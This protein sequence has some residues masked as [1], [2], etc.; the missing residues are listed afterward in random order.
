MVATY[1]FSLLT[2]TKEILAGQFEQRNLY[3]CRFCFRRETPH[4]DDPFVQGVHDPLDK[5]VP[6]VFSR[7]FRYPGSR[8]V[9]RVNRDVGKLDVSDDVQFHIKL[10]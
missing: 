1:I 8:L 2:Q 9:Q 10:V 4:H 6:R 7:F 5:I 3:L